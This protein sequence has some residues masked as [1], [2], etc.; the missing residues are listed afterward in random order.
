MTEIDAP[1]EIDIR[2]EGRAGRITLNRPKALNALTY[3]QVTA[4]TE[5]LKSWRDDPAVEFILLD[6]AGDRALCAGGDVRVLYDKRETDPGL[7]AR[8]WAD[9]YRLNA[10]IAEYPKPYVSLMDGIVMGGGIGLSAHGSHRIVTERSRLAMP[11]TTIGLIPDVGG[12]WLLGRAPGRLGEYFALTS[13]QMGAGDSIYAGFADTCVRSDRLDSLV[14][15]LVDPEGEPLSPTIAAFAEAPE[16]AEHAARQ[17]EIDRIFV[18]ESI[19]EILSVLEAETAVP[20]TPDI[21]L[22]LRQKS[23]LSMKLTLRL[24]RQARTLAS[25]REA[26]S[27]EYRLTT[28]LFEHGEFI[29]GVRAQ[30]VDKDRQ[31]RWPSQTLQ[32]VTPEMVESFFAPLDPGSELRF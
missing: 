28:R 8:F 31:P 17:A 4:M 3:P 21:A 22:T 18:A 24:V 12:S 9:E 30:L 26:L 16:Q 15:A 2:V 5:A 19:E 13:T 6:G 7:A 10:L 25:V 29:E 1:N 11:E 20:W 14:A 27:Y 32:A 23:P